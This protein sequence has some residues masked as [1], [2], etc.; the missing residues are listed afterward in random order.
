MEGTPHRRDPL[1]EAKLEIGH[2]G[3]N[4]QR[5]GGLRLCL[6]RDLQV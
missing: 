1:K 6:L 4:W 3:E 2:P 5:D